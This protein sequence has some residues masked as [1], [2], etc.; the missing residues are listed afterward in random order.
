MCRAEDF[1][2]SPSQQR[3]TVRAVRALDTDR[4]Y[5]DDAVVSALVYAC[6][7]AVTTNRLVATFPNRTLQSTPLV[8]TFLCGRS[9]KSAVEIPGFAGTCTDFFPSETPI[10]GSC[11]VDHVRYTSWERLDRVIAGDCV[12]D[13]EPEESSARA[14]IV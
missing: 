5:C 7:A 10:E 2:I 3:W 9:A 13:D 12:W 8:T 6:C 11:Q 1:D 14:S 4:I